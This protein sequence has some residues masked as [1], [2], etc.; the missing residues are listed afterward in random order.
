MTM[1]W[2]GF[3][4]SSSPDG[5]PLPA[6]LPQLILELLVALSLAFLVW[7]Y[8]RTRSRESL[9]HVPV[10]VQLTLASE[11]ADQYDLEVSGS[12]HVLASF[13]GPPS[14]IRELHEM[15]QR[16][17]VRVSLPVTVPP[18]RIGESRYRD[19]VRVQA[20][21]LPVPPGVTA[22]VPEGDNRIA[23]TLHRLG[24]RHLPVHLRAPEDRTSQIAVEPDM[25]L[26]RG[27]QDILER[28]R[29]IPTLPLNL[30][31][32]FG[33]EGGKEK[34]VS[35]AMPLV[36]EMEGRPV[37]AF[38]GTVQ[39]QVTLKPRP[40]LFQVKQVPVKFLCPAAYAFRPQFFNSQAGKI[41]VRV[42]AP[43]LP[44][45]DSVV[46]FIDLTRGDCKQGVNEGPL[47]LQL[48]RDCQLAQDP[49]GPLKFELVPTENASNWLGVETEP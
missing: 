14:R 34:T 47:Q 48:P 23:V 8:F 17:E 36:R 1:A 21:D 11:F 37:R 43:A 6:R 44:P 46:A 19:T 16:G 15:L 40:R 45:A 39:V 9:D 4:R 27:P 29:T 31:A 12:A 41:T 32:A 13:V 18:D 10:P 30:A 7:L 26:V 20:G 33:K 22:L 28:A 49:P 38:P 5:S 42:R 35:L 3:F 25:V 2:R 24:E